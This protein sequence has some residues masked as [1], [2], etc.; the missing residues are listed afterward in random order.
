ML[1]L[2]IGNSTVKSARRLPDD[3]WAIARHASLEDALAGLAGDE[4]ILCAAVGE[5]LAADLRE[6]IGSRRGTLLDRVMFL[7]FIGGSYDTPMTL[8]LDR[9]LNLYALEGDGVVISCGTAITVDAVVG[10]E[11][12]WGAILPGLT[13]SADSLHARIPVLPHVTVADRPRLPART[14]RDSVTNGVLLAA[15][16]A[17]RELARRLCDGASLPITLTGGDA[18]VMRDLLDGEGRVDP[19]LEFR[20]MLRAWTDR[21]GSEGLATGAADLTRP[22]L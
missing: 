14:S 9:I 17:A 7:P 19:A 10:G 6:R 20:G 18:D 1:F 5:M 4:E 22:P 2:E 8:G 16:L 11:P 21:A 13:T 12:R 3:S 15:A